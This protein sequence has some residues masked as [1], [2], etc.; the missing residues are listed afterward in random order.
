[1]KCTKSAVVFVVDDM[2]TQR[3]NT[4]II[5]DILCGGGGDVICKLPMFSN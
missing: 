2:R 4:E 1:M 3:E 5:I